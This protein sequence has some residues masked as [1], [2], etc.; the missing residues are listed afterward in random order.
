L[1]TGTIP[2]FVS[3]LRKLGKYYARHCRLYLLKASR[4]LLTFALPSDH[5]DMAANAF[6][7][8][9]SSRLGVLTQLT[10]LT[11]LDNSLSSTI[12]TQ[13]GLLTSLEVLDLGSNVLTGR[14]P[15][16]VGLLTELAGLS[17]FDNRLTGP[18]P[19]Q[20]ENLNRLQLLYLDGNDLVGTVPIGVCSIGLKE[21][22]SDCS[23]VQCICCTTCCDDSYGCVE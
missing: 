22:Y 23:E 21:F 2:T 20:L 17:F 18:I 10:H 12:P 16:Q 1:I 8:T 14:I 13:I 15:T 19:T 5:L 9:I 3:E 11:L 6:D 4:I 7:G